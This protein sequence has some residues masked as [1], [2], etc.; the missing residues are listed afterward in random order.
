MRGILQ[1]RKYGT[2]RIWNS[3]DGTLKQNIT[4]HSDYVRSLTTLSNGDLVSGSDDTTIRVWN[5]TDGTFKLN[6]TGPDF[7][8]SLA[9]LSNDEI[10]GGY[11][12]G[13]IIIYL[14]D[15][16]LIKTLDTFHLK[17][18]EKNSKK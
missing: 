15:G 16:T 3:T 11:L 7:V 13:S 8:Y 4:G 5:L 12:D 6:I 14:S 9:T 10:V 1:E 18:F 17:L 2:I